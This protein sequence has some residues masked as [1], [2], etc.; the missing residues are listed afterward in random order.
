VRAAEKREGEQSVGNENRESEYEKQL[1]RIDFNQNLFQDVKGL[2]QPQTA[3]NFLRAQKMQESLK[4]NEIEPHP[5]APLK[6]TQLKLS[7]QN[8]E[9][10]LE[11]QEKGIKKEHGDKCAKPCCQKP[12]TQTHHADRFAMSAV[13]DP[14]FMAPLYAEHHQIAHSIDIKYQMKRHL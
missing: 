7:A 2:Q 13:H 3:V 14:R 11:L 1:S 6:L 5:A 10:L 8:L 9:K 4:A 12:S